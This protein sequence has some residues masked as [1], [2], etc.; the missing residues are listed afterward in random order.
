MSNAASLFSSV[1]SV[2][3]YSIFPALLSP[4][5]LPLFLSFPP[6]VSQS[7]PAT[8]SEGLVARRR[9][10]LPIV[11]R[12]ATKVGGVGWGG[13]SPG[14]LQSTGLERKLE[15]PSK[16]PP[17]P[18]TRPWVGGWGENWRTEWMAGEGDC[19]HPKIP[20]AHS[21]RPSN[22]EMCCVRL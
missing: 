5:Y 4:A 17:S 19:G 18:L 21:R 14:L 1:H 13:A 6:A 22:H 3:T 2:A 8:F 9:D 15:R 10:S 12:S 7:T 16:C 20:V 11:W